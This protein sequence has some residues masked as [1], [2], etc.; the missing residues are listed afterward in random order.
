MEQSPETLTSSTEIWRII[1]DP[2]SEGEFLNY[3]ASDLGRIRASQTEKVLSPSS[4]GR[5]DR[6]NLTVSHG[7]KEAYLVHRLVAYAF[8]GYPPDGKDSVDH[9]NRNPKDNRLVNLRWSDI[10]EQRENRSPFTGD[11]GNLIS[12]DQYALNGEYVKTWKSCTEAATNFGVT[13]KAIQY[14]LDDERRT[15][16]GFKWRKT[17]ECDEPGEEWKA[18]KFEGS[19]YHVSSLG[20]IQLTNGVKKIG[21]L[22]DSGY[23]RIGL[24]SKQIRVHRIAAEHFLQPPSDPEATFVN[25]KDGDKKNNRASNLEWVTQTEN[26]QHAMDIGLNPRK[27]RQ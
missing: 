3:E 20:R 26:I 23:L 21:T 18:F 11:H 10:Y 8:L 16:V 19:Q 25:H 7:V 22:H 2:S 12:I 5:C 17:P 27:R 13:R 6:V 15:S 24:G 1:P 14:A 4:K 9:I